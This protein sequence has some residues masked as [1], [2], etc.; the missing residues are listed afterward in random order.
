[1]AKAIQEGAAA[2]GIDTFLKNV[3]D[4][5]VTDL[6]DADAVAIGSPNYNQP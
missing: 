3:N 4:V 1:M 2:Q 6:D 5:D